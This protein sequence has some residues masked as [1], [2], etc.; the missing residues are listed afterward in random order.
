[1]KKVINLQFK[2]IGKMFSRDKVQKMRQEDLRT[3]LVKNKKFMS[4]KEEDNFMKK[5]I[6]IGAE[7]YPSGNE[8]FVM[9]KDGKLKFINFDD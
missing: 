2:N 6:G 1:M 8:F 5:L 4:K 3:F 9:R 7:S